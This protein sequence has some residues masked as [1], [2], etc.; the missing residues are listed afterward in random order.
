MFDWFVKYPKKFQNTNP[1]WS[2]RC[3]SSTT[4]ATMAI[5]AASR[6]VFTRIR[7]GPRYWSADSSG[8]EERPAPECGPFVW[9]CSAVLLRIRTIRR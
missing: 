4:A 3:R 5:A 9:C 8:N 1:F 6:R 2:A 7:T